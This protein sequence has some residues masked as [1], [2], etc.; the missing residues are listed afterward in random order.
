LSFSPVYGSTSF[1]LADFNGDGFPDIV[2]TAGDNSDYSRILKPYHGVYIYLNDGNWNFKEEYFFPINGCFKVIA[3]DFDE[4]GDIDL[5][6]I[7]FFSD[8]KNRPQ[9]GFVYFKNDGN[10]DFETQTFPQ[11]MEGH[12]LTMDAQDID[13]DEDI[14]IVLG[15]MSIGPSNI[16]VKNNWTSGPAFILLENKVR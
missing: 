1:D 2:Y 15:N 4:D 3:R 14:D 12:W 7:S 11:V 10:M 8:L 16:K 5:A 6:T 9:E 13:G